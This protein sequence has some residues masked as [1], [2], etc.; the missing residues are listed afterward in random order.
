[1]NQIIPLKLLGIVAFIMIF[2]YTATGILYV[3]YDS[4]II[5]DNIAYDDSDTSYSGWLEIQWNYAQKQFLLGENVEN[6]LFYDFTTVTFIYNDW[7]NNADL[8]EIYN[9]GI[10]WYW[11]TNY[12]DSFNNWKRN[13]INDHYHQYLNDIGYEP[14]EGSKSMLDMIADFFG[15][16]PDAIA[17]IY[18]IISFSIPKIPVQTRVI[19]NI[20]FVPM[21]IILT[22]GIAPLVIDALKAIASFADA[23][24][25][26]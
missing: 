1:M 14:P 26:F 9:S 7:I 17:K 19:L 11:H 18:N 13:S 10:D 4:D 24:I 15:A 6:E 23:I 2:T 16:I 3:D 20:F 8:F 25:P 22:I 21:W 12:L 5:V